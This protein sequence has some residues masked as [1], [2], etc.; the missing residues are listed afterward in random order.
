[1][2]PTPQPARTGGHEGDGWPARL[3]P[4]GV[5]WV[6]V[7]PAGRQNAVPQRVRN[8]FIAATWAWSLVKASSGRFHASSMVRSI[9]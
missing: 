9:E 1:V 5:P 3:P 7:A 8:S 4:A 2:A 6:R